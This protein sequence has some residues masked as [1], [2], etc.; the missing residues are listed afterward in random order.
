MQLNE[1]KVRKGLFGSKVA[2]MT[3]DMKAPAMWWDSYGAEFPELQRF[4]IQILSLT[5]SSSGCERNWSAFEMVRLFLINFN[6]LFK[7]H[8]LCFLCVLIANDVFQKQ[9]RFIQRGET[10]YT[11]R[12]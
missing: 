11:K 2:L 4:A 6:H 9:I 3:K 1:F 5:C 12:K 7:C 10:I 8:L